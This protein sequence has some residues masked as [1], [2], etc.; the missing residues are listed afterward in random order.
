MRRS[1]ESTW[2]ASRQRTVAPVSSS[3][4]RFRSIARQASRSDSTKT[5][6]A[7]PRESASSP[8]A[9]EPAKRS[10]TAAP[11]TGPIRLNAASRTRSDVGRGVV[12][13]GAKIRA[14]RLLPPMIRTGS[15]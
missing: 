1:A 15:G 10:S 2:R 6:L 12:P 9:P 13:F 14:P 4:A 3:F 11:S 8:I 5:A 7:A